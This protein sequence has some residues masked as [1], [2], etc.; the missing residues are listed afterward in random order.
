MRGARLGHG[1]VGGCGRVFRHN[2]GHDDLGRDQGGL[3]LLE[4]GLADEVVVKTVRPRVKLKERH[5]AVPQRTYS[6][7]ISLH[8]GM[9]STNARAPSWPILLFQRLC[10]CTMGE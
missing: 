7:P 6:S 5:K 4:D 9:T 10:L 2:E 1:L 8:K 3:D